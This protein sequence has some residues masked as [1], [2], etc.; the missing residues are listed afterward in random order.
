MATIFCA[1]HFCTMGTG[2]RRYQAAWHRLWL[3]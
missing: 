1:I 3:R 2:E